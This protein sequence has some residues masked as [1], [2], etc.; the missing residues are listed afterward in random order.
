[1]CNFKAGIQILSGKIFYED[2]VDSRHTSLDSGQ[3]SKRFGDHPQAIEGV[4][5][6]RQSKEAP[7][8]LHHLTETSMVP[9]ICAFHLSLFTLITLQKTRRLHS[10]K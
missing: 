1:M 10:D 2:F 5:V 8:F 9:L 7:L 4:T 6:R 3:Q